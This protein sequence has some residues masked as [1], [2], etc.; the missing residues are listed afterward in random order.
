MVSEWLVRSHET[1]FDSLA[2]PCFMLMQSYS[3]PAR[4]EPYTDL[5]RVSD[6]TLSYALS[7]VTRPH[8]HSQPFQIQ[9]FERR[10]QLN[11]NPPLPRPAL[12]PSLAT[13]LGLVLRHSP[14]TG[15]RESAS[16]NTAASQYNYIS[17]FCS[18]CFAVFHLMY[19]S[20]PQGVFILW[21]FQT[22]SIYSILILPVLSARYADLISF[23]RYSRFIV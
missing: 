15:C 10:Q 9:P 13:N 21:D 22:E 20:P 3:A 12:A 19:D 2:F 5:Q 8:F 16:A 18:T 17:H 14:K 6:E 11:I 1:L 4:R 23:S 7:N